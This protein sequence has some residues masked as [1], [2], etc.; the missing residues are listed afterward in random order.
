MKKLLTVFVITLA[1]FFTNAQPVAKTSFTEVTSQLDP[2]GD[3]YLY[4]GTAQW[5]EHL[6]ANVEGWRSK[7]TAFPDATPE[8]VTNINKLSTS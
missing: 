2:G 1:A 8:N 3:F 4:L 7:L 5:L 6:S